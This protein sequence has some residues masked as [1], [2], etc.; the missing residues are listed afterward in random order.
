MMV[1]PTEE[2][3]SGV[4]IKWNKEQCAAYAGK[5]ALDLLGEGV[6]FERSYYP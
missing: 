5:K 3:G 4:R 2:G 6:M 1:R